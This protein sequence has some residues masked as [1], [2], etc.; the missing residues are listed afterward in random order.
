[1]KKRLRQVVNGNSDTFVLVVGSYS[2]MKK[3]LRLIL[4]FTVFGEHGC[5]GS[6]SLMKKRLRPFSV[7]TNPNRLS[8]GKLFAD[9]EAIETFP[10][11]PDHGSSRNGGKLFADEE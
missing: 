6:Y 10:M 2:L 7:N 8:G 5:V 9:E 1:M 11:P 4:E 3:R